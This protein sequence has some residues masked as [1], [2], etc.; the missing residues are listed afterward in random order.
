M[1]ASIASTDDD[2]V[3]GWASAMFDLRVSEACLSWRV[4]GSGS[5]YLAV[6]LSGHATRVGA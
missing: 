4:F 3:Q 5:S 6:I 1:V 2:D